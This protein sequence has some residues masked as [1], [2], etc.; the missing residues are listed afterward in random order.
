MQFNQTSEFK[1]T[2]VL[3]NLDLATRT[4]LNS[5]FNYFAELSRPL[6]A[7]CKALS[8]EGSVPRADVSS[9]LVAKEGRRLAYEIKQTLGIKGFVVNMARSASLSVGLPACWDAVRPC[10]ETI[11]LEDAAAK[12]SAGAA[13]LAESLGGANHQSGLRLTKEEASPLQAGL[14]FYHFVLPKML[15]IT[16]ALHLACEQ[17]LVRRRGDVAGHAAGKNAL[18]ADGLQGLFQ[19]IQGILSLTLQGRQMPGAWVKYLQAASAQLKPIVQ[20]ENYS[21]ASNELL[22]IARQSAPGFQH[23]ISSVELNSLEA[24]AQEV[25]KLETGLPSLI[26]SITLLELYFRPTD[27]LISVLPPAVRLLREVRPANST[28]CHVLRPSVTN[29]LPIALTA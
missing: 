5:P 19:D 10:L 6:F 11:E 28:L 14:D 2:P 21:R 18:G 4:A 29:Q 15:V 24:L 12:I 9:G 20:G 23:W 17:E 7:I 22:K 16:S 27:S 1:M 26:M 13:R 3:G 25:S 8:F